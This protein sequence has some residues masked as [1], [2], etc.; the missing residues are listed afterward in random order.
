M[1]R[2]LVIVLSSA[3]LLIVAIGVR[4]AIKNRAAHKR[5]L[6]YRS[7]V[8]QYLDRLT[9]GM[10]RVEVE[11]YLRSND[12]AFRQMCCIGVQR[13]AWADLVKIGQ[14]EPP[15]F[16]SDYGIYAAFEFAAVEKHTITDARDSDQLVN[17]TF[18]PWLE[19]CL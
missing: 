15:W 12:H 14:E 19:G 5:E 7:V 18:F 16:C 9:P 10:S 8:K 6:Q 2:S 17:V 3:A 1:N 13:D 11:T 4:H